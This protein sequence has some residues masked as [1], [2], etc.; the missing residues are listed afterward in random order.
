MPIKEFLDNYRDYIISLSLLEYK[1]KE[2]IQEFE[3]YS[4]NYINIKKLEQL[5][6]NI[7]FLD[8][9]LEAIRLDIEKMFD[10][11]YLKLDKLEKLSEG[12]QKLN[13]NEASENFIEEFTTFEIKDRNLYD[14]FLKG[15]S[16]PRKHQLKNL[17]AKSIERSSVNVIETYKLSDKLVDTLLK[18]NILDPSNTLLKRLSFLDKNNNEILFISNDS[19]IEIPKTTY[20]I[21]VNTD[22]VDT[23]KFNFTSLNLMRLDYYKKGNTVLD[24]KIFRKAGNLF[25]LVIDYDLP[26][27]CECTLQLNVKSHEK[28]K[29]K[30]EVVY[31]NLGSKD[32]ILL[33]D[34]LTNDNYIYVNEYSTDESY[35]KYLGNKVFDISNITAD[36]F[37]IT[38]SINMYNLVNDIE[39]PIIRGI[40][41]YVTN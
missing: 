24:D 26:E 12:Y 19:L 40:F 29:L 25:K 37:T 13:T 6:N 11:F 1:N 31:F 2:N 34:N 3:K 20:K 14:G 5:A 8:N 28:G 33:E 9:S 7:N 41:G 22:N 38:L 39:S 15:L 21:E 32:E 30:N 36:E 35:I 16:L 27:E 18:I 17:L 4:I 23:N 10:N